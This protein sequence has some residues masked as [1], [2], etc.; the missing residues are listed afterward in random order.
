MADIHATTLVAISKE[1]INPAL[2]SALKDFSSKQGME[3]TNTHPNESSSHYFSERWSVPFLHEIH[4]TVLRNIAAEHG[5][6]LAF[7]SPLFDPAN[8][9]VLAM[10]MDS[11]LINIECID[12]IADFAGKKA[13]V[14]KITEATMRGEIKDFKESLRKRVA[15][16]EGIS[17]DVLTSV[18][19]ERLRPNPG[20]T[21]L[22][23]AAHQRGLHTLLVSGGFTFFT[24][25]LREQMGFTQTQSNTLEIVNNKLTGKVLGNIVDGAAKASYLE[26]ACASLGVR[27]VQS[28]AMGDGANDLLMMDGAGLSVAY[29]AKPLV[30]EKADAAFDRVGLDA[31]LLL[32]D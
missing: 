13:D 27:K 28:I 1:P 17:V 5:S 22:L 10:D 31:T 12:E 15:L 9:R 3:I 29:K 4:R 11:T 30:K 26:Q 18:Y 24:D 6:D 7:L 16:L 23:A 14:A 8:I 25:Q 32:L 21:E 20:A 2:D 19:Q